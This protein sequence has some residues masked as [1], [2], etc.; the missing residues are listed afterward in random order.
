MQPWQDK[1]LD[2]TREK[3]KAFSQQHLAGEGD[4]WRRRDREREFSKER[5][6]KCCE[7]G[8]LGLSMKK[9][10][11]GQGLPYGHTIA[12]IEGMTEAC[13]DT[14]F[15]FAM[16]SQISGIQLALQT[17]GTEELKKK[18]LPDLISGRH[19]A[20]LGFTEDS[21]GSDV[22]S[23]LTRAKAV[24]G[25]FVLN[26]QKSFTTNSLDSTCCLVF[27]RTADNKSP[28][29]F[30]AF[31]VDMSWDGVSH[32]QPFEKATLRTCSMGRVNFKDVFV[33]QDH[34]IGSVGS[35]LNVLKYS[36][37]W[38]RVM[39]MGIILGPMARVLDETIDRVKT[40]EQFGKPIG[41][42]QQMSSKIAEMIMRQRMSRL[43][44]YDLCGRLSEANG[45]IGNFLQDVAITKLYVTESWIQFML[46]ATQIWAGRGVC[47]DWSIQ[48]DMRDALSGT[49]W[50]GTSET[51]R[52]T[53]A[54]IVG[55]G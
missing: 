47:H 18:W 30:S 29:D 42:Y 48:Q 1:S 13:H 36:I 16:S 44:V 34:V 17:S 55:V 12:A 24:D 25:G 4:E 51:L 31:M 45:A 8:V 49:I 20:C 32:G 43:T 6:L 23:T 11:G 35:G 33:P 22:F 9:E 52:N 46:D 37:G 26:G 10:Y 28:F 50:A 40:R 21:A 53:I 39:L 5:W 19:F 7:M 2:E 38:E 27:A 3:F 41:K 15:F 14:G 54:K